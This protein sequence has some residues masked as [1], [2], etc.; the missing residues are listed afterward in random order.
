MNTQVGKSVG[1][2]LLM[3]AG[4]LAA[5]FAMGVFSANGVGAHPDTDDVDDNTGTLSLHDIADTNDAHEDPHDE[6]DTGT[7]GL[8]I[9]Q[10]T[11]AIVDDEETF[12][13]ATGGGDVSTE[14]T[15]DPDR[16]AY[17]VDLARQW[18]ALQIT[19]TGSE[20]AADSVNGVSGHEI[21]FAVDGV[22]VDP[23]TAPADEDT[24]GD[25]ATLVVD[26]TDGITNKITITVDDDD[27]TTDLPAGVYT[28]T[29]NH[30]SA[31]STS[32]AGSAVRLTLDAMLRADIDDEIS[33]NLKGF[34]VP[35]GIEADDVTIDG[36]SPSDVSKSG[37]NLVLVLADLD[38][39]NETDNAEADVLGATAENGDITKELATIRI[40]QSAGITN[41]T[42]AG[43]YPITI[44]DDPDGAGEDGVDGQNVVVVARSVTVKPANATAGSTITITGKGFENGS[45]IVFIDASS[46]AGTA[47]PTEIA[48]SDEVLAEGIA[49]T[50]NAF[51]YETTVTVGSNGKFALDPNYINARDS[52]R[53]YGP[54][55]AEFEVDEKI[56]VTPT[57]ASRGGTLTITLSEWDNGAVYTVYISGN[58]VTGDDL[59]ETPAVSGYEATIKVK[60]PT[61][62]LGRGSQPVRVDGPGDSDATATITID[63][64]PLNVSPEEAVPGGTI[65]VQGTGFDTGTPDLGE[66]AIVEVKVGTE[67]VF[68]GS[69]L[70]DL[71]IGSGGDVSFTGVIP[72]GVG[73]GEKTVTVKDHA[74]RVGEGTITITEPSIEL[75]PAESRRGTTVKVTGTGFASRDQIEIAY[76]TEDNLV[77]VGL[78][79]NSGNVNL[80]FEVPDDAAIGMEQTVYVNSIRTPAI[81]DDAKHSTPKVSLG[82][83]EDQLVPGGA[84]TI[85]GAN[86]AAFASVT[87]LEVGGSDILSSPRPTTDADGSFEV[88][89]LVPQLSVGSHDL[90]MEAT[91]GTPAT[92]VFVSIVTVAPSNAPA[93]VFAPLGDNLQVV[94]HYDNATSMWAAYDPGAPAEINNLTEVGAGD[95]VWVEITEDQEFQGQ[96]LYAGW[97][98]IT[99]N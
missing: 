55:G 3:A 82:T 30:D 42:K 96:Q 52:K 40:K 46:D 36:T 2:A 1:F 86:M 95:I 59:V 19:A 33:V 70:G 14:E 22:A 97:N 58:E 48:S 93:D 98:L 78:S 6:W 87:K 26:L 60:V 50:D 38:D 85:R 63:A 8:S 89:A 39:G 5:L 25:S 79:D 99:L 45:A 92:T 16:H 23:T 47:E 80:E 84:M 54:K 28:V 44:S 15:V 49:I 71:T 12:T 4:L 10:G 43:E 53:N 67:D 69:A 11:I 18:T 65:T 17:S 7:D 13:A 32:G 29:L 31:A 75:N 56:E 9:V 24:T 90:K 73:S 20:Q 83:V 91:G 74:G 68:T 61:G 76:G 94:W 72:K 62:E 66:T 51:T 57:S 37:D 41:P 27:A 21:S 77:E 88:V 35:S 34:N 64:R 81:K